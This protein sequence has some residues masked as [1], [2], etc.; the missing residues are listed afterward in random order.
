[1]I[2]KRTLGIKVNFPIYMVGLSPLLIGDPLM[3][4]Q[5]IFNIYDIDGDKIIGSTD[6]VEL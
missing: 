2:T 1:M 3:K 6:L 4:H 5:F